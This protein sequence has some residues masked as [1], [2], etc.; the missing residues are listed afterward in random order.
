MSESGGLWA[1]FPAASVTVSRL[2]SGP[3]FGAVTGMDVP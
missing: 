3:V 1:Q 2:R